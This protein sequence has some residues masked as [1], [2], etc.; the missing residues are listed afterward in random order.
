M[1]VAFEKGL[2]N[3][4]AELDRMGFN[5][6]VYGEYSGWVDALVYDRNID[7]SS[8]SN[9]APE[10]SGYDASYG[11]LLV[12]SFKKSTAEVAEILRKRVYSA[13]F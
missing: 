1:V 8:I 4:R 9:L 5:T 12:N 3:M 10:Y 13:L 11:I 6:V 2:E 7:I